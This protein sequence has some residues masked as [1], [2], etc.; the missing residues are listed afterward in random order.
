MNRR[1]L[2]KGASALCVAGGIG[3]HKGWAAA[4]DVSASRI[5]RWRGFNLQARFG[6]GGEV[7]LESDFAMMAEWGF[8][9]WQLRGTF[10]VL[11]SGRK[12]V[13]YED[14]KNHKLDRKMLELLRAS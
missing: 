4:E 6:P 7:Y 14:F 3:A 1:E 11:D 2:L 9:L 13:Q 10:G 5:P 12:D 8:A